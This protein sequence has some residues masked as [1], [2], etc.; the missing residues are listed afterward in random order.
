MRYKQKFLLACSL[1]FIATNCSSCV[2]GS[3]VRTWNV[4]ELAKYHIKN[5]IY[6]DTINDKGENFNFDTVGYYAT[7]VGDGDSELFL[8]K[9]DE[10]IS[11]NDE[12]RGKLN[13]ENDE[14]R[15]NRKKIWS[16]YID[17]EWQN[18]YLANMNFSHVKHM[19]LELIDMKGL[20]I[21]EMQGIILLA[22]AN[23][24]NK[25]DNKGLIPDN[26]ENALENAFFSYDAYVFQ[27]EEHITMKSDEGN[28]GFDQ[29]RYEILFQAVIDHFMSNLHK[30]YDKYLG[31]YFDAGNNKE[32]AYQERDDFSE[33]GVYPSL[34]NTKDDKSDDILTRYGY[35]KVDETLKAKQIKEIDNYKDSLINEW[36]KDF[37]A[38]SAYK[39]VYTTKEFR[40][41]LIELEDNLYKKFKEYIFSNFN[42]AISYYINRVN[43]WSRRKSKVQAE[44]SRLKSRNIYLQNQIDV[45]LPEK[46]KSLENERDDI[47]NTLLPKEEA[48]LEEN[49]RLYNENEIIRR[50]YTS[51][52]NSASSEMSRCINQINKYKEIMKE[53]DDA[54]GPSDD[55]EDSYYQY[56]GWWIIDLEEEYEEAEKSY[57]YYKELEQEYFLIS[58]EY[59]NKMNINSANIAYYKKRLL[60]IPTEI[61]NAQELKDVTYPKE[62]KDNEEKIEKLQL[63]LD[64]Y[65]SPSLD[66][67]KEIYNYCAKIK[68]EWMVNNK[69]YDKTTQSKEEKEY[70]K[71]LRKKYNQI[72][73][74]LGNIPAYKEMLSLLELPSFE[75]QIE[76]F[77]TYEFDGDYITALSRKVNEVMT[78]SY[79]NN[80]RGSWYVDNHFGVPDSEIV[81]AYEIPFS[82]SYEG[83]AYENTDYYGTYQKDWEEWGY[84]TPMKEAS[85]DTLIFDYSN[86]SMFISFDYGKKGFDNGN[87][88]YK[89]TLGN[90]HL[91]PTIETYEYDLD[92]NKYTSAEIKSFKRYEGN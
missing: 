77:S 16:R 89:I 50:Q 5:N 14:E 61:A 27:S 47:N 17:D 3:Y 62:I 60:K 65:I 83:D 81:S 55:A 78:P 43:E 54:G 31:F 79:I 4:I 56:L 15:R 74:K 49:T 86:V 28:K 13:F 24:S 70:I 2:T 39:G 6:F 91:C 90:C 29:I 69:F 22:D 48:E 7:N 37:K 26:D 19:E 32:P 35:D 67:V 11:W 92:N 66:I 71:E 45:V 1:M 53:I 68:T 64:E 75:P 40:T 9:K 20:G 23:S 36:E 30:A 38:K 10:T 8:Q 51:S 88:R 57:N 87:Q 63:K 82:I 72:V 41:K 12:Y 21:D 76:L 25:G 52:K 84:F 44:I 34:D 85:S 18:D 80:S 59:V 58:N 33:T 73:E 46:I 42:D